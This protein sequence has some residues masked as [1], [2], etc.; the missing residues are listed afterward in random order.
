MLVRAIIVNART[1]FYLVFLFFL[2]EKPTFVVQRTY[3]RR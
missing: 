2:K 1:L 3:K